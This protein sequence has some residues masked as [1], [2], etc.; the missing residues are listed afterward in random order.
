MNKL[1][2]CHCPNPEPE[3][4]ICVKCGGSDPKVVKKKPKGRIK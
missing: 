3:G 2:P 4:E 1:K